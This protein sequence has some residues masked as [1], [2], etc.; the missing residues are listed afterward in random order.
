MVE[1]SLIL[2]WRQPEAALEVAVQ[3]T[4]IGEAGG[5]GDVGHRFAG[6][7]AVGG[8][9][10]TVRDLR[11]LSRSPVRSW[12]TADEAEL[13]DTCGGGDSP[14]PTSAPA[15]PR[16][17]LR[18]SGSP[19]RRAA[20]ADDR[21]GRTADE[22]SISVLSHSS[23]PLIGSS[24]VERAPR[25][26]GAFAGS[27]RASSAIHRAGSGNATPATSATPGHRPGPPGRQ[28]RRL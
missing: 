15:G 14:R 21:T 6:L 2:T 18:P 20:R 3:V 4:L 17:S 25:T 12:E 22:R 26:H 19:G 7:R 5:G 9:A 1:A 24:R 23:E 16:G 28:S 27:S 8:P 10:H 13:P 11:R